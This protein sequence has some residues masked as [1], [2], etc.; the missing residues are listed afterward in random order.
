[1]SSRAIAPCT[2]ETDEIAETCLDIGVGTRVQSGLAVGEW[3]L[4]GYPLTDRLGRRFAPGNAAQRI[5]INKGERTWRG[6]DMSQ[7]Q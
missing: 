3:L 2:I 4:G 5:S 7:A 6:I 1:M